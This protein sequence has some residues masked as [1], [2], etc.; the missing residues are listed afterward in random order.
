MSF[1]LRKRKRET[2]EE[3][4]K[5]E[6][7]VEG[8][9]KEVMQVVKEEN[10]GDYAD[11]MDDQKKNTHHFYCKLCNSHVLLPGNATFIKKSVRYFISVTYLCLRMITSD[12]PSPRKKTK[13]SN[14]WRN[15]KLLLVSD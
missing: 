1:F 9:N 3:K 15:T 4:K 5:M 14:C 8:D 10:E 13:G 12:F 7:Q 6:G 11:K 2:A